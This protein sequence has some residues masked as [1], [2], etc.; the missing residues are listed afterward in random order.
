MNHD[1]WIECTEYLQE[2]RGNQDTEDRTDPGMKP[3]W[4]ETHKDIHINRLLVIQASR[5]YQ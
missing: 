5:K 3:I 1:T 2:R 4:K